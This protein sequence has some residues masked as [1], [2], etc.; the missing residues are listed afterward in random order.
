MRN[1][2]LFSLFFLLLLPG[3]SQ[4]Q[5]AKRN[6][7]SPNRWTL[8]LTGGATLPYHD[9]RRDEY[10]DLG[11]IGYNVGAQLG[12][13]FGPAIGIRGNLNYGS[14]VGKLNNSNMITNFGLPAAVEVS[15][16]YFSGSV[17]GIFSFSGMAL[18]KYNPIINERRFGLYGLVGIGAINYNAQLRNLNTNQFLDVV[19]AGTSNGLAVMIPIGLGVSCKINPRFHVDLE[20]GINNILA[21]NFDALIMQKT[22]GAAGSGEY[23][24]GRNLD[25][26]GTINLNFVFH[27]GPNRQGSSAYWSRSLLQQSY[28]E[29]SENLNLLE[30]KLNQTGKEIKKHDVQIVALEEKINGLERQMRMS[31]VEMKKDSDGDGVPDVF[32]KENTKWDMTTLQV[33]TCGWSSEELAQLRKRA[34]RNEKINVD[35]S[36]IALDVDKD[37]VPDHLDKCPT[38]PGLV[39]CHGCMPE[40]KQ[41]TIKILTDLQG[42]EFE[43]GKSDF[44]DCAKKRTKPLQDACAI[45]QAAD[46]KNLA[47]LVAYMNEEQSLGFKLRI[48]GHTDDVGNAELNNTLSFERANSVKSRLVSMGIAEDRINIEGRGEGEPKF[49]PSGANGSFTDA[50]RTRNRRIEF[51]IE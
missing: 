44:V 51:V 42:L 30:N 40:T 6:L 36:G 17:V 15:T 32:D 34:E 28:A 48:I 50:D 33:S 29:Y 19:D 9:V 18:D 12:Y 2:L 43:S 16:D 26:A 35:G 37:G 39:S 22:N 46:M 1:A 14:V 31:E 20:A 25:K 10:I 21:D 4:A 11:D 45:K 8:A 13:W 27:L 3:L 7:Q 24:F 23:N 38:I 5:R 47:S 41:E 49:G